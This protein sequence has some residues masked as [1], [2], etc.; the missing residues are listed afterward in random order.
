MEFG[1]SNL[2]INLSSSTQSVFKGFP[3]DY[4]QSF[5]LN[6]LTINSTRLGISLGAT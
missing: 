1:E 5:N 6:S 2:L 3:L 4:Q